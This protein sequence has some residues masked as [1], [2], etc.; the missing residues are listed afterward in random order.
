MKGAGTDL[1]YLIS[2]ELFH[3]LIIIDGEQSYMHL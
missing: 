1:G 2:E 3:N